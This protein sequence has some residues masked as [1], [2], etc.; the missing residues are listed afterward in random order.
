MHIEWLK[1]LF[2]VDTLA[3][4]NPILMLLYVHSQE[5]AGCAVRNLEVMM[6]LINE[7]TL[8]SLSSLYAIKLSFT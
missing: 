4:K 7:N 1:G 5:N 2:R 3:H 8:I 6:E